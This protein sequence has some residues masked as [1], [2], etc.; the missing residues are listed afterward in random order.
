MI[1]I[2][3]PPIYLILIFL[4]LGT[5]YVL[6]ELIIKK[7][8]NNIVKTM[9]VLFYPIFFILLLFKIKPLT[10]SPKRQAKR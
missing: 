8:K 3:L 4:Y 1:E 10:I 5:G 2:I 6:E 9:F 7:S